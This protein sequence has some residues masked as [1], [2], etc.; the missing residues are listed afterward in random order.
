MP[1]G[2]HEYVRS[3]KMQTVDKI[4]DGFKLAG[5]IDNFDKEYGYTDEEVKIYI[6]K[7]KNSY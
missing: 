3:H 6:E 1:K 4:F 2:F 5:K 7:V